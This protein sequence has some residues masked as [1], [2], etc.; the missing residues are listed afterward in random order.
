MRDYTF[1]AADACSDTQAWIRQLT[2]GVR[3][4]F[5]DITSMMENCNRAQESLRAEMSLLESKRGIRERRPTHRT[6]LPFISL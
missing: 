3:S 5:V 1:S 6:R 2:E 4:L